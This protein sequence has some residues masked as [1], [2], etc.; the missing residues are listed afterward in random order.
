MRDFLRN[1]MDATIKDR[2]GRATSIDIPDNYASG[3]N[4]Q[5][6]ATY[7]LN[8]GALSNKDAATIVKNSRFNSTAELVKYWRDDVAL[9]VDAEGVE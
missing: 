8:C 4:I 5:K 6:V 2:L 9:I 7:L 3:D 1:K